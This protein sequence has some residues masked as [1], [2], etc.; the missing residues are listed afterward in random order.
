MTPDKAPVV[1]AKT[2]MGEY[3][4][5]YR[6]KQKEYMSPENRPRLREELKGGKL[7][8]VIVTPRSVDMK[9]CRGSEE[10]MRVAIE[11]LYPNDGR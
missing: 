4:K 10:E 7:I 1:S 8:D 9:E 2:T 11:R 3:R 5:E 6:E